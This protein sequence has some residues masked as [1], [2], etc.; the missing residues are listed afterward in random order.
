MSVAALSSLALAAG[1]ETCAELTQGNCP[2]GQRG[3]PARPRS[4]RRARRG[5]ATAPAWRRR[6]ESHPR[7]VVLV[8]PSAILAF[9]HKPRGT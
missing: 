6:D 8:A 1:Y 7:A 9:N 2:T 3:H 5:A 4:A